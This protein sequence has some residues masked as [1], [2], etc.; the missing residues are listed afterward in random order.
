MNPASASMPAAP[1]TVN[2]I[3]APAPAAPAPAS[4]MPAPA[5][6]LVANIPV[7]NQAAPV[8]PANEDAE[9]DKIMHDVGQEMKKEDVKPHKHGLLGFGH[10]SKTGVVPTARTIGQPPPAAQPVPMPSLP[11][12]Q[13]TANQPPAAQPAIAKAR[14]QSSMPVFVIFVAFVV[15]GFLAVTAFVAYRQ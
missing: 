4:P 9:L 2:D 11:P 7:H 14:N 13:A 10:K 1:R 3:T 8:A 15:T 12:Q 5:P 6:S